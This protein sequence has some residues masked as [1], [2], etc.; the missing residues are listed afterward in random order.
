MWKNLR[1]GL[2][3]AIG[4]GSILMMLLIVGGISYYQMSTNLDSFTEYRE[5]ARDTNLMGRVQANLL[6]V[7]MNV[8]DY[9]INNNEKEVQEYS[10]YM[11]KS[12]G[13]MDNA[14]K[15]IQ[16]PKR[17]PLVREADDLLRKYDSQFSQLQAVQNKVNAT[18]GDLQNKGIQIEKLLTTVMKSADEDGDVTAAYFSG[19]ALRNL[20]LAR[21]YSLK[22]VG[23][24]AQSDMERVKKEFS[25]FE[26]EYQTLKREV[27]NPHRQQLLKEAEELKNSYSTTFFSTL[28][29]LIREKNTIVHTKLDVMGPKIA[30]DLEDAKLSVKADQ[31]ELGPRV[32]QQSKIAVQLLGYLTAAAVLLSILTSFIINRAIATPLSKATDFANA[33]S[34]GDFGRKMPIQQAD[35]VGKI[36]AS[37]T[38]IEG[39]FRDAAQECENVV[40]RVE[41]GE[42]DA[43]GETTRFSGGF[44]E[45]VNGVNTLTNTFRGFIDQMPVGAISISKDHKVRYLNNTAQKLTGI[46]TYKDKICSDLF[47]TTDCNTSNCASDAC[48]RSRKPESS[49]ASATPK[50]GNYEIA[51]TSVPLITRDNEVVGAMEIVID[52]TKIKQAQDTMLKVVAEANVI[53]DRVASSSEQLSAQIEQASVSAEL[54]RQRVAET[55][56]AM[57]E[58]NSTVLEV[59]RNASSA[60]EQSDTSRSKAE[61]GRNIV[62]QV[63]TAINSINEMSRTQQNNMTELAKQAQSIDGVMTVIS[64]IADQTNLL[65]LNAAI[66]AARAGEAGRGFAV[67]ADEV[68]KLA[69]KTM[70]ATNEVE[71]TVTAIQSATKI[72]IENVNESVK[73]VDKAT[74]LADSSGQALSTIVSLS[75]EGLNL[76]SSIA[77]A[78]EEQS[79]TSEQINGAVLEVNRIIEETSEGMNQSAQAVQELVQTAQELRSVMERLTNT[80]W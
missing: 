47:C 35:E 33:V 34:K 69:E 51:Y 10:H 54:Q 76:I 57:E 39:A 25:E 64:D 72:N 5:L 12:R 23:S 52:Q 66:E 79:A 60:T 1:I 42:L 58:M 28:V 43:Q 16:S 41:H 63:V 32:Q 14:L 77:T 6:M 80:D 55:A 3:L 46:N 17:V 8:K 65:A 30:K 31:D 68:R 11:T 61:E 50:S 67:V 62:Q 36:C 29:P 71:T 20:L 7:R 26:S 2:K 4:F 78:A 48:M 40:K 49:E 74:T 21:F 70:D 37:I 27:Q 38:A 73:D 24:N 56:A 22:F 15:E 18:A 44:A 53:A 19:L 9:L 13:F 45:L 75:D 59:A